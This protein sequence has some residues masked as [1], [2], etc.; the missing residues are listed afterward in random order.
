MPYT[1]EVVQTNGQKTQ[2]P[3]AIYYTFAAYYSPLGTN[4][5]GTGYTPDAP[6]DGLESYAEL[7][8]AT[9]SYWG[10]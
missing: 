1:G 3:W 10:V 2:Y 5:H 6:Y 4:I 7:W 8:Q 9:K